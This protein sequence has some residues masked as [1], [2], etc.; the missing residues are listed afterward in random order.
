M[1]NM[2]TYT[3]NLFFLCC[4]FILL[5]DGL[6]SETSCK[7]WKPLWFGPR[8]HCGRLQYYVSDWSDPTIPCLC[9]CSITH[10]TNTSAENCAALIS[11][12]IKTKKHLVEVCM[13]LVCGGVYYGMHSAQGGG[14]GPLMRYLMFTVSDSVQKHGSLFNHWT[15]SLYRL[16]LQ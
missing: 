6:T 12:F 2:Q 14:E 3:G 7:L 10:V 8:P 13:S 5:M 11:V 15:C 4:C 1:G 9:L 16:K